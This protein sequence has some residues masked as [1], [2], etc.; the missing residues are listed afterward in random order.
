MDDETTVEPGGGDFG[1]PDFGDPLSESFGPDLGATIAS[2]VSD[3]VDRA[4]GALGVPDA[5]DALGVPAPESQPQPLSEEQVA[6]ATA[7]AGSMF[8]EMSR[9]L[10]GTFDR[11]VAFDT[12]S[13]VFAGLVG[14]GVPV[15]QAVNWATAAGAYAARTEAQAGDV[16]DKLID[17]EIARVGPGVN[18]YEVQE[19]AADVGGELVRQGMEPG[20]AAREA[21]AAAAKHVAG[22][23][24]EGR[25]GRYAHTEQL[26]AQFALRNEAEK[27]AQQ[28]GAVPAPQP[29]SKPGAYQTTTDLL[30][31]HFGRGW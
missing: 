21:I 20:Q 7:Q 16:R 23:D 28:I 18:R 5:I 4:F 31:K 13:T 2:A 3:G 10:G 27:A 1:E 19:L 29:E 14:D 30:Q 9:V 26:I 8:D 15:E 24:P 11:N 12:A 6:E 22:A 25:S 17:A